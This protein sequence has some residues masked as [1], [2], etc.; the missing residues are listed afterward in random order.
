MPQIVDTQIATEIQKLAP[1]TIIELFEIELNDGKE[2]FYF[3]SGTNG[4]QQN[5]VW[6]GVSYI[7]LPIDTEGFAASAQ[8]ELPRPK[9]AIANVDGVISSLIRKYDDLIG[10]KLIRKCTFAKYL[11]AVNF[12]DGNDLA[13]PDIHFP[14][15]IWYIDKKEQETKLM[16]QWELASAFDLQGIQLPKRQVIQNYCQWRYRGGECTYDGPYYDVNDR[17]CLLQSDDACAKKLSSCTV[18]FKALNGDDYVLPFGGF[19]G[20]TRNNG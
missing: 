8:G 13:N 9:L 2:R 18:R 1:D 7:A 11:D 6:Q 12:P 14:D 20:A 10:A 19:P 4:V 15:D 16:I 3:H 17:P 5:V